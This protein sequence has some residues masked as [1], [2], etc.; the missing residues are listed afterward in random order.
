MADTW[1]HEQQACKPCH[2]WSD[3][4]GPAH[5]LAKYCCHTESQLNHLDCCCGSRF[6]LPPPSV[7][8]IVSAVSTKTLSPSTST[9]TT[10]SSTTAPITKTTP[11][12]TTTTITTISGNAPGRSLPLSLIRL[13]IYAKI[14]MG[15]GISRLLHS[16]FPRL[17]RRNQKLRSHIKNMQQCDKTRLDAIIRQVHMSFP[18][19]LEVPVKCI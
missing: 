1:G 4:F 15:T 7:L 6:C 8:R 16:R 18:C 14:G 19:E 17:H 2:L 10:P 5:D 3:I 9:T 11:N 13:S 12:T